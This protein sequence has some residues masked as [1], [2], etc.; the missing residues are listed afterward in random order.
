MCLSQQIWHS[1]IMFRAVV[2]ILSSSLAEKK[3][4]KKWQFQQFSAWN[5]PH[6]H[7]YSPLC[8]NSIK[9]T[10]SSLKHPC[11]K[12]T[13]F[14][15]V[16]KMCVLSC[17]NKRTQMDWAE[18]I[19]HFELNLLWFNS[20]IWIFYLKLVQVLSV[21]YSSTLKDSTVGRVES[22]RLDRSWLHLP[23]YIHYLPVY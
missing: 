12:S 19:F 18:Y 11:L 8:W 6:S 23:L 3:Q 5:I 20:R 1:L 4:G 10:C 16:L 13:I 17:S 7:Y 21:I 22:L 2:T 9:S 15:L 14:N